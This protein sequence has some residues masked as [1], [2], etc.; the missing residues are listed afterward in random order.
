M[1][2]HSAVE[3]RR[4]SQ[5][6]TILLRLTRE[7]LTYILENLDTE[8]F[9]HFC[10]LHYKIQ[11]I[12]S[13][14]TMAPDGINRRQMAPTKELINFRFS[15]TFFLERIQ[16]INKKSSGSYFFRW[17]MKCEY[18]HFHSNF[19]RL[20]WF[21]IIETRSSNRKHLARLAC[22]YRLFLNFFL[23]DS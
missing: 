12:Q 7:S 5:T 1:Q 8:A 14:N 10:R 3:R 9:A 20:F 23:E 13:L 6:P 16:K 19:A 2:Q 4:V 17:S 18:Q 22:L 11:L 15:T 21:Y